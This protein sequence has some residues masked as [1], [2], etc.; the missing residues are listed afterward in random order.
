MKIQFM[1]TER[2][3]HVRSVYEGEETQATL[4]DID[5]RMPLTLWND[6]V[7]PPVHHS[8]E[9]YHIRVRRRV[10]YAHFRRYCK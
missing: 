4:L 8:T 6:K 10:I 3:G 9:S 7:C 1:H 2:M 5:T